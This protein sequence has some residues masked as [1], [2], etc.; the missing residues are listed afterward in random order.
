METR[1]QP[2]ASFLMWNLLVRQDLSHW[3]LSWLAS[4]C[5]QA[6]I[7][8]WVLEIKFRSLWLHGKHL[9]D[10]IISPVLSSILISPSSSLYPYNGESILAASLHKEGPPFFLPPSLYN[11]F[12]TNV[13]LSQWEH[14]TV[15]QLVFGGPLHTTPCLLMPKFGILSV[16]QITRKAQNQ[17]Y[18][19]EMVFLMT[20]NFSSLIYKLLCTHSDLFS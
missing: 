11:V 5:N 16:K 18:G 19:K 15:K 7:V 20:E 4:M 3:L 1:G 2:Q 13:F 10:W 9:T 8:T 12:T 6:C 17:V 14:W